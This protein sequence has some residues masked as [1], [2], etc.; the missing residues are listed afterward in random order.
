MTYTYTCPT[1]GKTYTV[2]GLIPTVIRCECG[3]NHLS[4]VVVKIEDLT[5]EGIRK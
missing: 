5:K 4:Y 3:K 1:T 2:T